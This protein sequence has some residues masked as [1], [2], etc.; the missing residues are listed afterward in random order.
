MPHLMVSLF[1]SFQAI[2]DG[3]P[4]SNFES[5]KAR[6]LLAFL[7]V[8]ADRPHRREGLAALFWSD[9]PDQSARNNLRQTLYRLRQ[10]IPVPQEGMPYLLVTVNEIQFNTNSDHWLDVA[11]FEGLLAATKRHHP[12]NLGLCEECIQRLQ[13]A[14]SLYQG[15][16]LSGFSLS[17]S[18]QFDWWLLRKQEEY[19]RKALEALSQA[20]KYHALCRNYAQAGDL[21]QKEIDLEPW[22]EAAHRRLM[23]ALALSGYRSAAL[24]Q[25]RVCRDILNKDLGIEPSPQTQRLYKQILNGKILRIRDRG[26]GDRASSGVI[27]PGIQ[28]LES[29]GLPRARAPAG[30]ARFVGREG[31]LARLYRHLGAMIN[32]Q[33]QVVFVTGEAGSGKTT[34]M[35]EFTRQAMQ[36][37]DNLLSSWG[38]GSAHTGPGDAYLLFREAMRMLLGEEETNPARGLLNEEHLMRIRSSSPEAIQALIENGPDLVGTLLTRELLARVTREP[39]SLEGNWQPALKDLAAPKRQSY[40]AERVEGSSGISS[41]DELVTSSSAHRLGETAVIDQLTRVLQALAR[42]HPLV[43]V[44]D[45]LQWADTGSTDLLFHLGRRLLGTRILVVGAYRPEDLILRTGSQRHPLE[46]V[47]DE[48]QSI[49]GDI[50]V[51]LDQ[52]DGRRFVQALLDS[53]P[54]RFDEG[55][56]RKLYE[57]SG[58]NALFALELLRD[59]HEHGEVRQDVQGRWT[60]EPN[61]NWERLSARTESVISERLKRLPHEWLSL[62]AAASVQGESFIAEAAAAA[63]GQNEAAALAWL[64]GPLSKQHRLVQACGRESKG[65]RPIS[66]FRFRLTLVQKYLYQSLDAVERGRL[67]ER[68]RE[69][70]GRDA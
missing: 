16:F 44:L 38:S 6:A 2:I 32:S 57:H 45:D 9:S 65:K 8:E 17:S 48:L 3:S 24:R 13:T 21:A 34:L 36:A 14:I 35:A 43:M 41:P 31:E 66:T 4:V 63:V 68:T 56:H 23:R 52:A 61:L 20:G 33:G 40:T 42:R 54:N 30:L 10:A 19:H 49:Y 60:A 27:Y 12:Q 18:P 55:F 29:G 70:I 28:K 1:G 22:R 37:Y 25:Y 46:E 11:A 7:M 53:E 62:L 47:V 67:E 69:E 5:N 64:S 50:L 39:G 15:D 26:S 51:D 59:F 58:G